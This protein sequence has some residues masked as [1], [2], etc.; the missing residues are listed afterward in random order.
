MVP[1]SEENHSGGSESGNVTP[2]SSTT[3]TFGRILPAGAIDTSFK[4]T[5]APF[6]LARE[7]HAFLRNKTHIRTVVIAKE[8]G[9]PSY[10]NAD[11]D[12][13]LPEQAVV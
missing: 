4:T 1:S 6:F 5:V 13:L 3:R 10:Q 7:E 12:L 2:K 9:N 8:K 11:Q